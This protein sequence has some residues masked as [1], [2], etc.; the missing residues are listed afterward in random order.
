LR[1]PP[2]AFAASL[3]E[4]EVICAFTSMAIGSG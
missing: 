4:E 3:K 2:Y 1:P